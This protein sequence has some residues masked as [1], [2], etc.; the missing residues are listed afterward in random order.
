MMAFLYG[1]GLALLIGSLWLVI[2]VTLED[3]KQRVFDNR[4]D[5]S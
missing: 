4:G 5:L 3:R 1:V 2:E